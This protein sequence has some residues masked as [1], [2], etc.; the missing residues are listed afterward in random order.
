MSVAMGTTRSSTVPLSDTFMP[1]NSTRPWSA[2]CQPEPGPPAEA[3]A[4]SGASASSL[5]M[6]HDSE[7]EAEADRS[8]AP[9]ARAR[10]SAMRIGPKSI[11]EAQMKNT[12][13]IVASA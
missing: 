13:T 12:N 7:T 4:A 11:F 3:D 5:D 6:P 9:Q 2:S 1:S 10:C 8:G